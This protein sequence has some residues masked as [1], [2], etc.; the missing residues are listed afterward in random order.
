[1]GKMTKSI[2]NS[3]QVMLNY[4]LSKRSAYELRTRCGPIYRFPPSPSTS[5]PVL[6]L[7]R[8]RGVKFNLV[9]FVS[10]PLRSVRFLEMDYS[11]SDCRAMNLWQRLYFNAQSADSRPDCQAD[12]WRRLLAQLQIL[13]RRFV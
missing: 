10:F 8:R 6:C 5:L 12:A 13:T 11:R 7:L 4:Y 1:M 3:S 2:D 9:P